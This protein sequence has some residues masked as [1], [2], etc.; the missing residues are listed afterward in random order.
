MPDAR[1]GVGCSEHFA[2]GGG[3]GGGFE[4]VS[5]WDGVAG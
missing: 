5:I 4:V 1:R 2:G 3:G